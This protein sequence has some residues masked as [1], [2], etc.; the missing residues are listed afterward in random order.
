MPS[1]VEAWHLCDA[2]LSDGRGGGGGPAQREVK[3]L[4]DQVCNEFVCTSSPELEPTVR[5]LARDIEA[6]VDGRRTPRCYAEKVTYK[7]RVGRGGAG[8]Q[9][10]RQA[11]GIGGM[12]GCGKPQDTRGMTCA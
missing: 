1:E 3:G 2:R 6:A 9:S 11:G 4:A 5:T 10:G 8:R 7:V 12:D